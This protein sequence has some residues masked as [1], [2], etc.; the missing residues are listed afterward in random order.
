MRRNPTA[1]EVCRLLADLGLDVCSMIPPQ[2]HRACQDSEWY[3]QIMKEAIVKVNLL[4]KKHYELLHNKASLDEIRRNLV[5]SRF[6]PGAAPEDSE[7][8]RNRPQ[9]PP[10]IN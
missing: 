10:P 3:A 6:N 1:R 7:D 9:Q 8:N 4:F 2:V 5:E